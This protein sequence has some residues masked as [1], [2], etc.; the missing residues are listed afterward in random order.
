MSQAVPQNVL[1]LY[2]M[3]GQ[4]I[5]SQGPN[6]W[7]SVY[8]NAYNVPDLTGQYSGYQGLLQN[9]QI[10]TTQ[11]ISSSANAAVVP[12]S[13]AGGDLGNSYPNPSV[14]ALQGNPIQ[15]GMLTA[16]QDGYVLTWDAD[17][18]WTALPTSAAFP[19]LI[20]DVNGPAQANT[21][22]KIQGNNVQSGAL[23]GGQA[24]YVFTWSG[25]AWQAQAATSGVTFAGDLSGNNS[26]QKVIG[27]DGYALASTVPV[28]LAVPIYDTGLSHYDIR[29]LTLDD[30]APGFSIS[31]YS[32][33]STVEIGATVTNPVFAASYSS[34][35]NSANITNTDSID[36]PLNLVS[37]FTSGT[38][39]GSF[40][41][42]SQTSVTFTLTAVSTSTKT[43]TQAITYLPRMFGGVG[44]AGATSSVTAG[45]NTAILS[46]G[47]VLASE[48]LT[49]NPVGSTYT[50]SPSGQ[51]IY[52]LLTGGTHTF[53]AGGFAFP[54]NTPTAVS[55][56]NQ[57]SAVVSMYLYQSTNTLSATYNILVVS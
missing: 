15:A 17:G 10:S 52:L 20:G 5:N 7:E 45:V 9:I 19:Q 30:I 32:G 31:G 26:T 16:L 43:A 34:T 54:M 22:S 33:G 38:V 29:P 48:G 42:T 23:G 28:S 46:N 27:L 53:S 2:V 57:N 3:T 13:I 37:P 1:F 49:S 41:H 47:A 50:L 25:T 40:H 39:I 56:T 14:I 24:G 12:T 8:W 18:Y 51:C 11:Q 55:F 44:A 35:P 4:L 6:G 21:V 36:S